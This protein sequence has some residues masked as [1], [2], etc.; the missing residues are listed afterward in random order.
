MRPR[1]LMALLALLTEA[2]SARRDAHI[3]FLKL[4]VE[5]LQSRL[6]GDRAILDPVERRRLMKVGAEMRHSRQQEPQSL[7]QSISVRCQRRIV[8]GVTIQATFPSSFRLS[9]PPS[10][11]R[12]RR[13]SSV[14]LGL[15]PFSLPRRMWFSSLRYLITSC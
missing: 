15:L 12:R 2:W 14:D 1:W 13:S 4:Q 9:I 7:G 3:R 6:L 5:M 11:A 10:A 8:S